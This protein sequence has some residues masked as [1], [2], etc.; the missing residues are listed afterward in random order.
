MTALSEET[1][2]ELIEAMRELT[3]VVKGLTGVLIDDQGEPAEPPA[4]D[5]APAAATPIR[6]MDEAPA[7]G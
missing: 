3:F 2:R 4:A 1:A 7:T 5:Q 6:Y